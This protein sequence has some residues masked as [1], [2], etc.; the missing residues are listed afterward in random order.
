[1]I[2]KE[3][4]RKLPT[5]MVETQDDGTTGTTPLPEFKLPAEMNSLHDLRALHKAMEEIVRQ[6]TAQ[7]EKGKA[8]KAKN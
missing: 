3:R 1:M 6:R 8:F 4:E 2:V 5:G 7:V